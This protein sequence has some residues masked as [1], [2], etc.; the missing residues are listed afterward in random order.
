MALFSLAAPARPLAVTPA[1]EGPS[2]PARGMSWRKPPPG[3]WKG[4]GQW[5]PQLPGHVVG[6]IRR[7]GSHQGSP[8]N[9][10]GGLGLHGASPPTLPARS[11]GQTSYE[12]PALQNPATERSQGHRPRVSGGVTGPRWP[13]APGRERRAQCPRLSE[14]PCQTVAGA[15]VGWLSK[16]WS[17]GLD[18]RLSLWHPAVAS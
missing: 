14:L 5:P 2:P 4:C 10:N 13:G 15:P 8:L 1:A 9:E 12:P 16:Q 7:L 11:D 3:C 18:A 6:L 17:T